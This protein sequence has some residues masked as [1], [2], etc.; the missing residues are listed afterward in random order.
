MYYT[1]SSAAKA[2]DVAKSTISK[3]I[4]NSEL[5]VAKKVGNSFRIDPAE[6]DRWMS[7]R[8]K[9]SVIVKTERTET[10]KETAVNQA[11]LEKEIAHLRELLAKAEEATVKAEARESKWQTQA[12]VNTR[13]LEDKS[14]PRTKR[15][16]LEWLIGER[17]AKAAPE[18]AEEN[19][20]A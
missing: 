2:A 6:L 5:S 13:L 3:A 20:A 8:E 7:V 19:K 18:A 1:L 15:S 16:V 11:I 9:R 17:K 4:K 14:K 12:E 10:L